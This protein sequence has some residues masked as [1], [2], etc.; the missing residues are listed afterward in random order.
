MLTRLYKTL[1]TEGSPKPAKGPLS[2]RSV[3]EIHTILSAA[4]GQAIRDVLITANAATQSKPPT[5]KQAASPEFR[6]WTAEEL[7]QFLAAESK[8]HS[9]PCGT[10]S[11][12]PASGAV[13]PWACAGKT[14]TGTLRRRS[15]VR[16][17]GPSGARS[18]VSRCPRATSHGSSTWT[19]RR[20][21]S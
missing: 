9:S 10:S 18:S 15:S 13:R 1:E 16:R 14:S 20:S 2:P 12:L 8:T 11:P 17:S 21:R 19:P 6:V 5:A 3:R 4:L 7:R